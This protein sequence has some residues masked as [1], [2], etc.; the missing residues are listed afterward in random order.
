VT[1]ALVSAIAVK[2]VI[3][4]AVAAP[5]RGTGTNATVALAIEFDISKLALVEKNGLLTGDVEVS[6]VA[7][8]AKGKVHPGRRYATTMSLKKEAAE[9]AF[10]SGVRVLSKIELPKGKYQLRIAA[11]GRT[12]AGSVLYDL[13]VPDFTDGL[14]LSGVSL[15]SGAA[16]GLSTFR[17]ADP[18]GSRL[19]APVVAMRDFSHQDTVSIYVEAYNGDSRTTLPTITAELRTGGGAVIGTLL[20]QKQSS[21]LNADASAI[22]LSAALPLSEVQPGV[23]V[24][25][26]EASSPNRKEIV[27]RDVPIRVW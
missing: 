9:S 11:G 16:A 23:Y 17:P 7:T 2:D 3:M 15:T 19:P 6:F 22:G 20:Q 5:Y 13:D 21:A 8:D 25:H 18:V 12:S 27:S 10:R 14:H 26:V 1:S 24:I 4:R